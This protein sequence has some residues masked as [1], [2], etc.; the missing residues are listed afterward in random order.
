MGVELFDE[1]PE[2]G[3]NE[4]SAVRRQT[5]G[6]SKSRSGKTSN[7]A[8]KKVLLACGAVAI[9]CAAVYFIARFAL[10]DPRFRMTSA[11]LQGGKY[12]TAIEVDD[13][14][15]AD[16]DRSILRVPLERRRRQVEQIPWVRSATVRRIFPNSVLVTV[17]ERVPV[18][19]VAGQEAI[20]LIDE[21]GIILDAP[22]DAAFH[23][24]VVR[25]VSEADSSASR[26]DKM[27]L[28]T[29]LTNDLRRGG[30]QSSASVSEVD[31]QDPQDARA[32]VSDSS[33]TVLVHLGKEN[34]LA[35]YLIYLGHIE[36]WKK[37]FPSIQSVDLRYEGQVVINA[38]PQPELAASGHT[39]P[40]PASNVPG[41]SPAR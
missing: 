36:E 29:A 39:T 15:T 3:A 40:H 10:D 27:H 21:D 2:L 28:F 1:M 5:S 31:L 33:G 19:F 13:K 26:R 23:F 34:F 8:R 41:K 14:F 4:V 32:I 24:P 25:G 7:L 30:L 20:A 11:Q 38:D 18:A 9:L 6:A 22:K 12:V 37:K 17:T 35:R 16:K